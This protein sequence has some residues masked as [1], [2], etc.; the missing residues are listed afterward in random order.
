MSAVLYGAVVRGD[1]AVIHVGAHTTIGEN[2]VLTA[3]QVGR[4]QDRGRNAEGMPVKVELMVGDYTKVGAGATLHGCWLDGENRVG[5]GVKIGNGVRLEK[6]A[7]ILPGSVVKE[8]TWIDENEVWE[9]VPARK[10][11][12]VSD[13]DRIQRQRERE[14]S[15][16]WIKR[17]M[18]EFL[19]EGTAYWEKEKLGS[20]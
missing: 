12:M 5:E 13:E 4:E 8:G 19:P 1:L 20:E 17:H 2:A 16:G 18:Y 14:K 10:V 3:G 9:G 11:G 6:G 7:E 15:W